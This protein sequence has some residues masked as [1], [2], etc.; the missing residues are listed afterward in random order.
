MR[1]DGA[2]QVPR[3]HVSTVL[4]LGGRVVV[5]H[6]RVDEVRP[7]RVTAAT[8]DFQRAAPPNQKLD[9]RVDENDDRDA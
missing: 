7:R 6:G 4:S 8:V 2:T 1:G 5:C 3:P 9:S